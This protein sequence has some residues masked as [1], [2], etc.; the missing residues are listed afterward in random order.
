[1]Y[2][3]TNKNPNLTQGWQCPVCGRVMAP[4]TSFCVWCYNNPGSKALTD[5]VQRSGMSK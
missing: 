4:F 2:E 5:Q 1:M 3:P